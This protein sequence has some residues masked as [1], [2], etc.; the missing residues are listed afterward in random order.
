MIKPIFFL[1]VFLDSLSYTFLPNF[2]QD[3]AKAAGL[4]VG[5]ASMPFTAYYLCF[6][7]SL[8]PAGNLAERFGPKLVILVGLLLAGA[9][10]AAMMLPLGIFELTILRGIA[11]VGQGTLMIGVQAYIL[12]VAS[13]QKK[14]Q[15]VAIIV[16]G[17]QGGLIAGMALGSLLVNYL[18]ASGVFMISGA[19]GLVTVFYTLLRLPKVTIKTQ[20]AGGLGTSIHELVSDIK[21]AIANPEFVKTL[22]CVGIPAKAILTSTITFALP[23]LLVQYNYR[24]ED[25]GQIIM[26]YGLA[27]MAATV[28]ASRLV[29][30]TSNSEQILFWGTIL[31]GAGLVMMG[32]M[33]PAHLGNGQLGTSVMIAGTILVGFAHGFINA[34]VVIHVGQ[35]ELGMRIGVIP[36]TTSYRF[37]ER[38]GHIAGPII[39]AQVFLVFGQD[40]TVLV[41]IGAGI[42]CLGLLFIASNFRQP[43][44]E[45]SPEVRSY[46]SQTNALKRT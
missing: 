40:A 20:A 46:T 16:L 9:S 29:D 22:L 44:R 18:D 15:G 1:A 41:W 32:F 31:S 25:I 5:Y 37:L 4:S 39:I 24:S 34:P 19:I 43:V 8:L 26:L 21:H 7:L 38:A 11:G 28:F 33:S 35:S 45:T 6:A 3:A 23:L 27:V 10:M 12:T 13:P 42:T 17:F 14:T 36:V 2:M 30:R